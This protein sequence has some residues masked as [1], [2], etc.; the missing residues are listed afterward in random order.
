MIYIVIIILNEYQKK[1]STTYLYLWNPNDDV[2]V[3]PLIVTVLLIYPPT[4]TVFEF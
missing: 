4:P 2:N 1:E 3:K